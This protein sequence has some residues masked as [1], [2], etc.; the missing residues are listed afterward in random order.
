MVI[1]VMA[2]GLAIGLLILAIVLKSSGPR[3]RRTGADGSSV[4]YMGNGGDSGCDSGSAG[5]GG[6]GDGGGGGGGD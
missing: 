2:G 1:S 5:D 3:M 6:C 4:A